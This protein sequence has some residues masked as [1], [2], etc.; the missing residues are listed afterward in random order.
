MC[1]DFFAV[2]VR[3]PA[4]AGALHDPVAA[5]V[6]CAPAPAAFTYVHG[7]AI[8]REGRLVTLDLPRAVEDHNRLARAMIEPA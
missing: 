5:V 2:D 3:Q 6:L 4:F 7:R 1:A 8:V